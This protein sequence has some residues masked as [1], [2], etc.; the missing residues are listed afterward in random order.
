MLGG[1]TGRNSKRRLVRRD[2]VS[3]RKAPTSYL[4]FDLTGHGDG[5]TVLQFGVE[6]QQEAR[7]GYPPRA[8][9]PLFVASCQG[10]ESID[11]Y[12]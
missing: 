4:L 12:K 9:E 5:R 11:E 10:D 6:T 8:A 3:T 2:F 1:R 7:P